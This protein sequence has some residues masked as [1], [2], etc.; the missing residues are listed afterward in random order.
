MAK[1]K[2]KKIRKGTGSWVSSTR[3]MC[4]SISLLKNYEDRRNEF[5]NKGVILE[6]GKKVQC[7]Y[8]CDKGWFHSKGNLTS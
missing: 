5:E 2:L 8:Y 4:N 3:C 7:P 6:D 1:Q